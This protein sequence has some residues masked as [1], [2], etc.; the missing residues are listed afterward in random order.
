MANSAMTWSSVLGFVTHAPLQTR[1]PLSV[2]S[3]RTKPADPMRIAM[4]VTRIAEFR[5]RVIVPRFD[6]MDVGQ[7]VFADDGE[8][9]LLL[10]RDECG[11]YPV[12][13]KPHPSERSNGPC[14]R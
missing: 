12:S 9:P 5:D 10:P 13:V 7:P 6:P 11:A 2:T 8:S 3:A 1:L 14:P 4:L